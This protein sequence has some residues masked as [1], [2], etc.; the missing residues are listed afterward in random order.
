MCP[1]VCDLAVC[2]VCLLS[3][4]CGNQWGTPGL[5]GR[6]SPLQHTQASNVFH[7]QQNY[8]ILDLNSSE[9]DPAQIYCNSQVSTLQKFLAKLLVLHQFIMTHFKI[10]MLHQSFFSIDILYHPNIHIE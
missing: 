9:I 7:V 2:M 10:Q 8:F 5:L 6:T 1:L 4:P 3:H